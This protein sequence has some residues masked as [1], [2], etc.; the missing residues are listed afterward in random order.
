M[1]RSYS[2]G[3]G[4]GTFLIFLLYCF[5]LIGWIKC[6]VKVFQCNWDPIGKAEVIYTVGACTGLGGVIGWIDIKDK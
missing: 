1:K 4:L 5:L 3:S 2:Q 6:V